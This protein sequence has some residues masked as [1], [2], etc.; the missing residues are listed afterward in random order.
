MKLDHQTETFVFL[1]RISPG[2]DYREQDHVLP[3][4][5]ARSRERLE[6]RGSYRAEFFVSRRIE[7][8]Y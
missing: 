8:A 6:Q 2:S 5:M 3:K 7:L 4:H 1:S